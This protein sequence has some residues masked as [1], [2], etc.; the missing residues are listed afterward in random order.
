MGEYVL[1]L[2][3]RKLGEH[4]HGN[5]SECSDGKKGH[6]P[7]RH[8]LGEYGDLLGGAY[9]E[10]GKDPGEVVRL[11]LELGKGIALLSA[12]ELTCHL[13]CEFGCGVIIDL[14]GYEWLALYAASPVSSID[15]AL[16]SSGTSST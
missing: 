9:S 15:M 7:V 10:I 5:P 13:L 1:H 14:T 6:S 12:Y 3:V 2:V 8:V 4:R 11:F 16:R